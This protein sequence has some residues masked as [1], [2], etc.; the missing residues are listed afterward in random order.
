MPQPKGKSGNP[1]GRPKGTPNKITTDLRQWVTGFIQSN[2]GQIENDWKALEPKDRI[3]MFEKLL[4]YSLPTLQSVE[5]KIELPKDNEYE[6]KS[7]EELTAML[8]ETL[9]K[10]D[11]C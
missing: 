9:K 1:N 4:K 11:L 8:M 5:S 7:E 3:I 10:I 6:G 2:T